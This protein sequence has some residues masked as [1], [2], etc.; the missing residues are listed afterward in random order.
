MDVQKLIKKLML[1][2]LGFI[3]IF[4]L[5]AVCG[6]RTWEDMLV[7]IFGILIGEAVVFLLYLYFFKIHK[8]NKD[9]DIGMKNV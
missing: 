3:V 4:A 6:I 7:A 1:I 2:P 5:I 8:N 9:E